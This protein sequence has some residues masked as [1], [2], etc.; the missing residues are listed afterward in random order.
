M[1]KTYF[2]QII[3]AKKMITKETVIKINKVDYQQVIT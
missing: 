1:T 2:E 3:T